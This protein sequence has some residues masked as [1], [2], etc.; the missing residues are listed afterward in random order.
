M[1]VGK[2]KSDTPKQDPPKSSADD[3]SK[4]KRKYPYLIWEE[5]HYT[6]DCTR[7][8]EFSHLLK[9]TPALLKE[10]FPS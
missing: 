10:P 2:K 1:V 4:W 3:V 8:V 6:K 7:S 9:G 5:D